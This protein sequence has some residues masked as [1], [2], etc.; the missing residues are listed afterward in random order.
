MIDKFLDAYKTWPPQTQLVYAVV[1]TTC[2][3]VL[4]FLFG[5]WAVGL[6]RDGLYHLAVIYR[7]WPD[8]D[9]EKIETTKSGWIPWTKKRKETK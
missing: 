2:V 8:E 3:F 6:I 5:W 9:N 1:A 7:G 4:L